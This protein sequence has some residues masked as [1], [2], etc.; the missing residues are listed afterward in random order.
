MKR[1]VDGTQAFIDAG[2]VLI[3]NRHDHRR[4]HI[5]LFGVIIRAER[6]PEIQRIGVRSVH[7]PNADERGPEP[8]VKLVVERNENEEQGDL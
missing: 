6:V 3:V 7:Q 2:H 1:Q 8:V 5:D 4:A